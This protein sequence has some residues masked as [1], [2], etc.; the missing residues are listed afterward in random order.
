MAPSKQI[1]ANAATMPNLDDCYMDKVDFARGENSIVMSIKSR[2]CCIEFI[3]GKSFS[4]FFQPKWKQGLH[5][6][7]TRMAEIGF[8]LG[9]YSRSIR[10]SMS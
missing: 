9:K 10:R 3:G 4:F 5:I 7:C 2:V 1:N 6:G 8:K